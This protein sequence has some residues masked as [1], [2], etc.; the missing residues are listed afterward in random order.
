M[1]PTAHS[2]S[3]GPTDACSTGSL[4]QRAGFSP[5]LINGNPTEKIS[6]MDRGL[7]YGDGLFETIAVVNGKPRLWKRHMVR[8]ARGEQRLKLPAQDKNKVL[9]EASSLISG[10]GRAVI[11]LVVTRGQGG[12]GYRPSSAPET[13]RILSLHPW[14][15]C[16]SSWYEKGIALRV[17][18]TR[19]GHSKILAGLKHLNRL[20]QVLARQEWDDPRIPEGLMLDENGHVVEG[21]QSNLFFLKD[22]LL[23]TPSLANAGVAGIVRELVLEIAKELGIDCR[24]TTVRL[25][26]VS[27]ADA[28]F[29]TN[30]LLGICPVS[31]L[32]GKPFDIQLI[33]TLLTSSVHRH[34][35]GSSDLLSA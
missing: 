5:L 21:T 35:F 25:A 13:S 6:V 26:D 33:P 11:K 28:L 18:R 7:Q 34:C 17:C 4:Q 23:F 32:A 9:E 14:P 1:E 30:S 31:S 12:R 15:D 2:P 16:P 24:V 3:A 27:S 8:L 29:I 19:I 22:G 20:E 10:Q